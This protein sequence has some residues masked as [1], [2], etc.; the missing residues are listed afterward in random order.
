[1]KRKDKRQIRQVLCNVVGK[2]KEKLGD[3]AKKA[4]T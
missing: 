3:K 4:K 2:I 1:M